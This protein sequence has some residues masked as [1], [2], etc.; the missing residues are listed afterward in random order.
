MMGKMQALGTRVLRILLGGVL[1]LSLGACSVMNI[2]DDEE[3]E[4]QKPMELADFEPE[5]R[6]R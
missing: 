1:L 4:A 2:F 6:I 3:D 5:L